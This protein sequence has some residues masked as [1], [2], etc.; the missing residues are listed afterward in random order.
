MSG[1]AFA[2]PFKK[3][4]PSALLKDDAYYM[5]LAYNQSVAAWEQDE[6]PVGA[7][8][9]LEGAVIGTAHNRVEGLKDPTAHAEVLAL[10]QAAQAV[11]DWRLNGA[12]LYVTKEPCPMCSGASIMARVSRV[13][14]AFSDPKMGFLGGALK[15]H[16]VPTLNH[17]LLVTRGV[18]ER[19]CLALF[20]G[21]FQL[22]RAAGDMSDL[23]SEAG[24]A[25][26]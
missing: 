19:E 9:E 4:F 2:C 24:G 16:E 22:K 17:K 5:W 3:Q 12:T 23:A 7:V 10:T 11:G 20:Q 6:V 18:L 8:V 1:K 21:Y 14:Y 15:V 26:L 25:A 13:V